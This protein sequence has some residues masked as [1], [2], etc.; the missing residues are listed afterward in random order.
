VVL[1]LPVVLTLPVALTLSKG[2]DAPQGTDNWNFFSIVKIIFASLVNSCCFAGPLFRDS[3][4]GQ[5]L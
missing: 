4:G 5:D 1:A 2:A 3:T